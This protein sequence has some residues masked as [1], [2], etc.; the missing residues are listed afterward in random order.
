MTSLL[1]IGSI[2]VIFHQIIKGFFILSM[3]PLDKKNNKPNKA[4]IN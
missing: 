2:Q 3:C 4:F 1:S